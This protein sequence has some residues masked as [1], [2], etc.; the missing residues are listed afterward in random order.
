MRV[1]KSADYAFY[2]DVLKRDNSGIPDVDVYVFSPTCVP[3][4]SGGKLRGHQDPQGW[5]FLKSIEYIIEKLPKVVLFEN[6]VGFY[7]DKESFEVLRAALHGAGYTS[8]FMKLN[9]LDYSVPQRRIRVYGVGVRG[10]AALALPP[11]HYMPTP[12]LSDI[13]KPLPRGLWRAL[14]PMSKTLAYTNVVSCLNKLAATRGVQVFTQAV[15][16]DTGATTERAS[17]SIDV[18]FTM[19][20]TGCQ[21]HDYWVT[22][23]GGVMDIYDM[24]DCQGV[25]PGVIDIQAANVSRPQYGAML[26][27]GMS[28]PVVAAI[29]PPVLKSAGFCTAEECLTLDARWREVAGQRLS[30]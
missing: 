29:F 5:V 16:I 26:G 25:L 7:Q 13:V 23:K 22:K 3:W 21:R 28:W 12:T 10:G 4:A 8:E 27:N 18:M 17:S 19:T 9:S 24:E 14:P 20:R 1:P 6:V 2:E 30:S 11:A 15:A